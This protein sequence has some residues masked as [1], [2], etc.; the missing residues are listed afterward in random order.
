[1]THTSAPNCAYTLIPPGRKLGS[2]GAKDFSFGPV[3][4]PAGAAL[5]T[6]SEAISG[7]FEPQITE[8]RVSAPRPINQTEEII[9]WRE[10]V[11]P[12][13]KTKRFEHIL[14]VAELAREIAA[15]NGLDP[16]RAELAGVLHD[17]ARDL[18]GEEL[19]ELAP[20]ETPMDAENPL[21]LHGR[22]ARALLEDWG[23]DDQIV[24]E[25]VED[26]VTGPRGGN[27][28]ALAV[29]IADVSEPG[30]GVNH[31]IREMAFQDLE[32]AYMASLCCKV[33]YL[34]RCGKPVH[35]RTRAAYDA[36]PEHFVPA[37]LVCD[38]QGN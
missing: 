34:E 33:Q 26:H 21:A 17:L 22:A 24:L 11:R 32:R 16:Y 7:V 36:L 19:L 5:N 27:P 37:D 10:R 38:P 23:F 3:A 9:F 6:F 1:M 35:P 25:A 28:I 30:R 15:A 2:G 13:V 4:S 12:M 20:A 18:T 14:R 29:Y 31:D 8:L